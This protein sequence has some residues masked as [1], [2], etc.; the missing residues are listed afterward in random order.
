M[1]TLA[2]S[3]KIEENG[4]S[5]SFGRKISKTSCRVKWLVV[6]SIYLGCFYT[7]GDFAVIL[8]A[9]II[10]MSELPLRL[11][12]ISTGSL[13]HGCGSCVLFSQTLKV[14]LLATRQGAL[15]KRA[16]LFLILL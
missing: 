7:C 5:L 4:S 9:V 8:P 13:A 15:L 3:Y 11:V 12:G 10:L 2:A 14:I 6:V 1:A 16:G